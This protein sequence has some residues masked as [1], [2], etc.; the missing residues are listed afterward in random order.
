MWGVKAATKRHALASDMAPSAR[1]NPPATPDDPF[2]RA[3]ARAVTEW[4]AAGPAPSGALEALCM[5]ELRKE[6]FLA[7][8]PEDIFQAIKAVRGHA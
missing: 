2:V 1:Q 3:I 6:G 8:V 5:A 7:V 4:D